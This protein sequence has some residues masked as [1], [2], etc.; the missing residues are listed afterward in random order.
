MLIFGGSAY[1]LLLRRR[2]NAEP[3][4]KP[5]H[6]LFVVAAPLALVSGIVW[7]CVIA[8]EMSV[9]WKGSFD[10]ATLELAGSAT[11]FGRIFLVRL[12]GM[13]AL[14]VMCLAARK[15]ASWPVAILAALLLVSLAP[16]SHAAANGGAIPIFR[17][18]NDGMHLLAA[19]FWLGGLVILALLIGRYWS[20]AAA[21]IGPLRIFSG[22]GAAVV[23][24]LVLTGVI[25]ALT[26]LPLAAMTIRNPYFDL[27]LLK[28]ALAA[29][30]IGLASLNRWRFAPALPD[31]GERGVRHLARSV[32]L[33]LFLGVSIVAVVGYL[34]TMAPH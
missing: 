11:R 17:A 25:N 24:L 32:G 9:D 28:I 7:F 20:E 15:A 12:I 33:E 8:G 13:T 18:A 21:L 19:G 3:S 31:G 5:V 10:P 4:I 2:D 26:I 34:G 22:W 30:M 27:L 29:A 14:C 16:V 1:M 23:A 6:R